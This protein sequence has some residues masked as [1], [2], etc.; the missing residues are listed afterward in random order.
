MKQ[1]ALIYCRVS[2]ERQKNEGHG[3]DSQEHRCREYARGKEYEVE[4]VFRDSFTGGGDFMKRPAMRELLSYVDKNSHKEYVVIFDDLKRFARDTI[5]H[6]NL[7]REFRARG[8]RP[9]CLNFNFDDSPEGAFVE[10]VFAAQGQLEREQNK[11]QVIQKQKARLERGYWPFYHPPGY[12]AINNPIHGKL[13]TPIQPEADIIK[14]A[15]EGFASNRFQEQV[16]VQK[17]LTQE[18]FG[19]GKKIYLGMVGQLLRRAIYAG[20]IEYPDW[21]VERREGHHEPLISKEV[22][23]RVQ[24]KLSGKLKTFS[25]RDTREDFALRGFVLCSECSR[26]ITASWT[27]KKRKNYRIGYYRCTTAGCPQKN[28]GIN[29]DIIDRQFVELL[30]EIRPKPAIL[31]LTQAVFIKAWNERAATAESRKNVA[32]KELEAIEGEIAALA[33]R[34][35]KTGSEGAL[36]AYEREI[37][38]LGKKASS[39]REKL[40][41]LKN[42]KMNFETALSAV[43]EFIKNPHD[44]WVNGDLATK[45]LLLKVVFE[46]KI[47]YSKE[48]GFETANLALP[49]RVFGH[50]AVSKYVGVEMGGVEP[51]CKDEEHEPSTNV[52]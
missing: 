37:E 18:G 45:R 20:Y 32:V 16:D 27:T 49:L 47:R 3:L 5:F 35:A 25:R 31:K 6:W 40:S 36:E 8:L 42:P 7:R 12:R 22:F 39:L 23:A 13:L 15:F 9:E 10:T 2:S 52:V 19:H 26:P 4:E 21:E 28:K 33:R 34:A 1:R 48:N 44:K 17:F 29:K 51:P 11:R 30:S 46:S 50:F 38:T 43:F 24:E 41:G 14:K